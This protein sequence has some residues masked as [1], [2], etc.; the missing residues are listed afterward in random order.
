MKTHRLKTESKYFEAA[1]NGQKNFEVRKNDRGFQ[2]GDT[3]YLDETIVDGLPTGRTFG[4][5][6]TTYILEGEEARR[7]GLA[8]GYCIFS[9]KGEGARWPQ[10]PTPGI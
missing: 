9:W 4:P 10:V 7:F 6:V 5:L 3:V 8:K 2:V 1:V